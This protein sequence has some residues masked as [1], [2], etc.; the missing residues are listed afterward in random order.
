VDDGLPA[1]VRLPLLSLRALGV[2]GGMDPAWCDPRWGYAYG[3]GVGSAAQ[4]SSVRRQPQHQL[5][6]DAAAGATGCEACDDRPHHQMVL[7]QELKKQLLCDDDYAE[8]EAEG[9]ACGSMVTTSAWGNTMQELKS[10]TA[11]SLPSLPMA[12]ATSNNNSVPISRSP[13]N[14]VSSST[15]SAIA[16]GDR[17]TAAAHLAVMKMA[18][19]PPGDAEQRLAAAAH[20][21]LPCLRCGRSEAASTFFPSAESSSGSTRTA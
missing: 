12:S 6:Q 16:D 7:L 19:N 20:L 1:P 5:R 13:A 14:S 2:L 10:I 9:G 4:V 3:Y 15:A 18:A 11:A 17:A 21:L 8:A